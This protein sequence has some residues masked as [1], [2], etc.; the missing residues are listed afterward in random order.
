MSM[1]SAA[2][3]A[4]SPLRS[5]H[6]TDTTRSN[7]VTELVGL[8]GSDLG[9][10]AQILAEQ[11]RAMVVAVAVVVGAYQ[12]GN[13]APPRR[14]NVCVTNMAPPNTYMGTL[15]RNA[16]RTPTVVAAARID[17]R[18]NVHRGTSAL[19]ATPTSSTS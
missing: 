2:S 19:A 18:G 16:G 17:M 6:G 7:Q 3:S 14:K 5:V 9:A 10:T 15:G 1:T 8:D 13:S 12:H 11:G 4:S